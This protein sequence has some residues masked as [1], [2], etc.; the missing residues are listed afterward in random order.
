MAHDEARKYE[1]KPPW[2]LKFYMRQAGNTEAEEKAYVIRMCAQR[3][4]VQLYD[5]SEKAK[6]AREPGTQARE[7]SCFLLDFRSRT[8]AAQRLRWEVR[9][10]IREL[11]ERSGQ[12]GG[13]DNDFEN[14]KTVCHKHGPLG[15]RGVF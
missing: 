4:A 2:L 14:V 7:G 10:V 11:V 8:P 9:P 6:G 12:N 3:R 5:A 1:T 13:D 15:V